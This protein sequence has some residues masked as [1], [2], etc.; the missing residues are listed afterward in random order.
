VAPGWWN[1]PGGWLA[2]APRDVTSFDET[3]AFWP[4]AI[5]PWADW[6]DQHRQRSQP[7]AASTGSRRDENRPL[8]IGHESDMNRTMTCRNLVDGT[9][10]LETRD[11]PV[12]RRIPPKC[13]NANTTASQ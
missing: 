13:D 2:I 11:E 6:I 5:V 1:Y 8:K 10:T 3:A 12:C 7:V 9:S 4:G